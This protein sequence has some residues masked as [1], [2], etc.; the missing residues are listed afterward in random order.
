M[1]IH[2]H[3]VAESLLQLRRLRLLFL[4]ASRRFGSA[5]IVVL[6]HLD[7]LEEL[8]VAGSSSPAYIFCYFLLLSSL[9]KALSFSSFFP[10]PLS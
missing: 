1:A 4:D 8:R 2:I 6:A 3:A 5:D 9:T 10:I 7:K